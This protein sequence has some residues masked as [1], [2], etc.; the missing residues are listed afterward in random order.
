LGSG[1]IEWNVCEKI[2]ATA[3][4]VAVPET[5]KALHPNKNE[6]KFPNESLRYS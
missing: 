6:K 3:A 5:V 2:K 4:L 1:I